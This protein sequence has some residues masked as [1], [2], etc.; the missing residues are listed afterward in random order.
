MTIAKMLEVFLLGVGTVLR[1]KG[2]AWSMVKL[3]RKATI[4]YAPPPRPGLGPNPL[5]HLS[6]P[7]F[8]PLPA[9]CTDV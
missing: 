6:P 9:V 5:A 1:L 2:D 4:E 7:S 3:L 8:F